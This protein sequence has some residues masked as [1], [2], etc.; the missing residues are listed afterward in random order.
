MRQ[1]SQILLIGHG[2]VAR[3]IAMRLVMNEGIASIILSGRNEGHGAALASLVG[4]CGP[5]RVLFRPLDACE[6][7]AVARLLDEIRPD[8][9]FQCGALLSPWL[10][11]ARDDMVARFL[12]S[13]GFA[14]QLSAQ[15]PIATS[16]MAA[17]AT[18]GYAGAV[19]NC[20][21]PDVTNPVLHALGVAPLCGV[22]N[23]GMIH[24][25]AGH[26]LRSAGRDDGNLRTLAHH[27]QVTMVATGTL[28]DHPTSAWPRFYLDGQPTA[29]DALL[30][31]L[32]PLASDRLLNEITAAHA[33]EIALAWLGMAPA[34]RTA[35]PGPAG[36]A[37]GWPVVVS[38]GRIDLDLPS[39]LTVAEVEAFNAGAAVHDG[40]ARIDRDGTVHYSDSAREAVAT[41]CPALAEP[42]HPHQAPERFALLR[43][44]LEG[45]A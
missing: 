41:L 9:V 5:A 2:D 30:A 6:T 13:G 12:R 43:R 18:S 44:V 8:L 34:L 7:H 29:A 35:V 16:V 19:I 14:L 25:L 28:R 38:A 11:P 22:G 26:A 3:R 23:A 33:V 42:L 17:V 37:G 20:S 24:R 45:D 39:G 21:F 31:P 27:G 15:L 4:G 40:V 10:L 1:G 36:R 32:A